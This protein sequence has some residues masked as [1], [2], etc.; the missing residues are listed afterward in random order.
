[1]GLTLLG[2]AIAG[3]M[4]AEVHQGFDWRCLAGVVVRGT[5]EQRTTCCCCGHSTEV[6]T[7]LE[8]QKFSPDLFEQAG[9][10]VAS[11]S[12]ADTQ[13]GAKSFRLEPRCNHSAIGQKSV[14][15][16]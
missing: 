1:M 9:V 2:Q 11:G 6:T 14:R 16:D 4:A 12:M 15:R 10:H 5:S 8:V 13:L 3:R 7:F